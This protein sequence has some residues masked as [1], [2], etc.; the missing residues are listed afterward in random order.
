MMHWRP[1]VPTLSPSGLEESTST[2]Y[3]RVITVP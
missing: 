1:A 2:V 3:A